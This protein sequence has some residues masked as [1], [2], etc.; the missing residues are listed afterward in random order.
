[1][2]VDKL[3]SVFQFYLDHF[4]ELG[5]KPAIGVDDATSFT[6]LAHMCVTAVNDFIPADRMA[7]SMRWLGFIQGVLVTKGVFTLQEVRR[8]SSSEVGIP[9]VNI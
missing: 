4:A 9:D 2:T 7:K 5:Y 3:R 6:H 1:V 8:H